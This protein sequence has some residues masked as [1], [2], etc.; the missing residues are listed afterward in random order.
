M[1]KLLKTFKKR[2]V[3][4]V[5]LVFVALGS[6]YIAVQA[7][8]ADDGTFELTILHLNDH[9]SHL[10]SQAFD[11][12]LPFDPELE[13]PVVRLRLGGMSFIHSLIEEHR[14]DNSLLLVSGE[15]NGTLF[16][17]MF[18][19]GEA[20]FAVFNVLSPDAY[21]PGNHEFNEGDEH[22]ANLME[23][24]E[25]PILSGNIVPTELSP[26]Y[27]VLGDKPYVIK[28]IDGHQIAIIGVL[29]IEKTV[30]SSMIS[31]YVDFI[32]ELEFVQ[33]QVEHLTEQGI[34][35]IIVLS[36]LGYEFDILLA[37]TVPNIDII[38]GG[39]THDLLD[40][41]GEMYELQLPVNGEFPTII[42]GPDGQNVFI[43]QSWELS[44]GL[45]VLNVTFDRDGRIIDAHGKTILPV[46]APYLVRDEEDQ[47]VYAED[48]TLEAIL[49]TIDRFEVLVHGVKSYTVD[50]II[51]P[52]IDII[53]ETMMERIG[54][55][56]ITLPNDRIP[57]PFE[58]GETPNGS[59]AAQIV[60][61]AFLFYAPFADM[62]IQNAG[63]I[64]APLMEGDFTMADALTVL[65]FANTIAI[66]TLP[67]SEIVAVLDEAIRFSQGIA[68]STG[69]FP[70]ASALRFEVYLNAPEGVQSAFNVEVLNRETGEW[71]PIDPY[72]YYT[73]VTNSFTVMGRDN[74]LAF[75]RAIEND[76]ESMINLHVQYA[77]PLID[78][79]QSLDAE[80]KSVEFNPENFSI[81]SVREWQN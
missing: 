74:Y 44:K 72:K 80:G 67:G 47:W 70:Y 39:D 43:I 51:N 81:R 64:R 59:F 32:D 69:A 5:A 8:T 33:Y 11:L 30:R 4:V 22:F 35:K 61:D 76:P 55:I 2:I 15:L 20:D 27:G 28:E 14:T 54:T 56:S 53:E 58:V 19:R 21:M 77:V 38:A 29:K 78:F 18:G 63:G 73:V 13:D 6:T 16:Y 60:A 68:Q 10:D 42:E 79:I 75:E 57:E 31:E 50:E 65:P 24:A 49:Y 36:H 12:R 26:L 71:S 37:E 3:L 40:S 41:T 25:F 9:H 45:G 46:G 34:N 7:I 66:I 52:M 62:A 1:E 23:L 48:D 17:S